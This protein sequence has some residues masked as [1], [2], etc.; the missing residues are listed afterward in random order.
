MDR[1][2]SPPRE[3]VLKDT[4]CR[5]GLSDHIFYWGLIG[6]QCLGPPETQGPDLGGLTVREAVSGGVWVL[7]SIVSLQYWY[8]G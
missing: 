7:T 8:K 6:M 3:Q 5:D 1:H 4:G 2:N